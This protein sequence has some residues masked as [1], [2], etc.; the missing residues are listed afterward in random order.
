MR[1]G[2]IVYRTFLPRRPDEEEEI[3]NAWDFADEIPG[4]LFVRIGVCVSGPMRG[5]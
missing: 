1:I 3:E 2:M 4:V 5:V